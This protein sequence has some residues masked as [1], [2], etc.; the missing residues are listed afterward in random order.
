MKVYYIANVWDTDTLDVEGAEDFE[1]NRDIHSAKD[2]GYDDWEVEWLVQEISNYY[3][4]NRD[5]W[6]IER[7]WRDGITI[8]LWDDNKKLVGLFE[9]VLEYEPTFLINKVKK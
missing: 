9:T 5:G 6:E 1:T 3:F 7:T 2:E 4:H 8:A